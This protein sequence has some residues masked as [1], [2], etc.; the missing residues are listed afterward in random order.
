MAVSVIPIKT[1]KAIRKKIVSILKGKTDVGDKVFPNASVPQGEQNLPVILVYP[2]TEPA[3]L[4]AESPRELKREPLFSIEIVASGPEVD[5]DGNPPEDKKELEDILDDIAEQV[6]KAMSKDETF[7][8]VCDDSI[9]TSTDFEFD[10]GGGLPIGSARL[11][12]TVTY[13][14]RSPD[15]IEDQLGKLPDHTGADTEWHTGDEDPDTR[16]AKD[17]IAVT[18]D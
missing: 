12:Y 1:R 8:G 16:E 14:R 4:Y 17:T 13:Y 9:L 3:E 15:T 18:Q 2:R 5:E 11:Q 6:E 10:G 7:G